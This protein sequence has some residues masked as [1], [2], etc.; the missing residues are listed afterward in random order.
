MQKPQKDWSAYYKIT[1]DRPPSQILI[2]ALECVSTKDKAIDIGGG[3]LKD[4]RYL[5][6]QGFDVTVIDKSPLMEQEAKALGSK[7]IHAFT[8]S[9]ED[10]KFP[11]NQYDIVSAMFALPFTEPIH[12]EKVFVKIKNSL[13]RG[14]IFCGH[15]FGVNDEWSK[16]PSMTFHTEYQIRDMCIGLEILYIQEI[17]KDSTTA[18]GT[19]K[20]WH[21]FE[22]VARK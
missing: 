10:F 22:I 21:F 13:K 4:T 11:Q 2:R 17:E 5:L 12:F 8:A 15:F 3:A 18:D 7:N 14:G 16:N 20:H 1:K 19:P 6:E 9:F